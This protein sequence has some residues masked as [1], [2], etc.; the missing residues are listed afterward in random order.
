MIQLKTILTVLLCLLSLTIWSQ[1]RRDSYQIR[2]GHIYFKNKNLGHSYHRK[3][4]LHKNPEYITFASEESDILEWTFIYH[5]GRRLTRPFVDFTYDAFLHKFQMIGKYHGM[6]D[7]TVF[8]KI[9]KDEG[10]PHGP[11]EY[12]VRFVPI[13]LADRESFVFYESD[14][15]FGRDRRYVYYREKVV[16]G[17]DPQTF[18]ILGPETHPEYRKLKLHSGEKV[19]IACGKGLARDKENLYWGDQQLPGFSPE[20]IRPLGNDRFSQ[21]ENIYKIINQKSIKLIQQ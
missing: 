1:G 15:R 4:I 14:Q 10:H 12:Y 20:N 8:F 19:K 6:D 21:G 18:E 9:Y 7:S 2:K 5:Q 3:Y 11:A 16:A 17:A 13:D